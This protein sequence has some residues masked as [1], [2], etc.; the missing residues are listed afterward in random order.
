MK[1]DE[2]KEQLQR[3][4]K[5]EPVLIEKLKNVTRLGFAKGSWSGNSCH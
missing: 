4:L 1:N 3:L 5:K 2:K